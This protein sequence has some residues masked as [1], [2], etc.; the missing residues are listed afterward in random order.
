MI[1]L[2][3]SALREWRQGDESY[4][5]YNANHAEIFRYVYDYFP[6]PY[7]FDDATNWI[8]INQKKK[9]ADNFAI[10]VDGDPV[11]NMGIVP[12][13][14]VHKKS[15]ALGYWLGKEYWGRGI[16]TEA[17]QWM[18]NYAFETFNLVRLWAGVFSNN[19]ASAKV[20]QKSGFSKEAVLKK[21]IFK[22]GELLDEIIF[23]IVK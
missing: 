8:T 19:P 4:L 16:T 1:Q 18:V 20:L 21:N 2:K 6:H 7:T 10:L 13:T 12:G 17:T 23:A 11:G 22:N 3:T 15:A 5:A 14:D 9:K